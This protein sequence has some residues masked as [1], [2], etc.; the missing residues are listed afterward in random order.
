MSDSEEVRECTCD[1]P[2]SACFGLTSGRVTQNYRVK[3]SVV[4][5]HTLFG[6]SQK[7]C[8]HKDETEKGA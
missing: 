1:C 7:V 8:V 3:L 2:S 5:T 6:N 4:S